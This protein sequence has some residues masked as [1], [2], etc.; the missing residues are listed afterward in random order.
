MTRITKFFVF[1]VAGLALITIIAALVLPKVIDPNNYRDKISQLVFDN[2]GLTLSIDG[3]IGWSVFPWLGLTLQ[4][5]NVKGATDKPFAE[6]GK[7][8]VSV[9]L[10]PLLSQT[11]EMQTATLVGLKLN[12]IKDKDGK[13]NWETNHKPSA[14]ATSAEASTVASTEASTTSDKSGNKQPLQIDIANVI[15]DDLVVRYQD[16]ATGKTYTID[17]ASLKTGAI[18]NQEPFDFELLARISSNEPALAFQTGLS[19]NFSFDLQNGQYTLKNYKLSA[20]PDVAQ[21]ESVNLV[22]NINY[23]QK[24][25]QIDGSMDVTEFNP[26]RLLNQIKVELPPMADPKALNKLSF[27]SQFTTDGKHFDANTLKLNLDSFHIDG[28]FKVAD[29]DTQA[30]TFQF[31]G[32]DLNLDNY[33]PPPTDETAKPSEASGSQKPAPA[34]TNEVPLIP[35]DALRPLDIKGSLKLNSLIVAKLKFENPSVQLRAANGRQEVKINS[36]F[37]KG[38]IDLDTRLDVRQ[39]GN[40]KVTTVAGLKGINLQ[41]LAEPVPALSSVEGNLN[42]DV[43]VATHGLLQSTLTKNLSGKVGFGIGNGAFTGANFDKLVC[44][45]IAQIRNKELQKKDWG[46]STQFKN[47]SGSF[48]IRNGVASNDNLTAALSNLNLK[49][50][51]KVNLIQQTMDYHIGLN[52]SGAT[53]PDSD[54]ACQVN[55]DYAGVTWP[56]RCRGKL[57]KPECGLDTER[58]ADTIAGLAKQEVQHRIEKEIEKK[59][60]GPLKDALKGFFK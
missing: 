33:L 51:G 18:R 11:V 25:M 44:E 48:D 5:V 10:L 1:V 27:N 37:Y 46:E 19:G 43:N 50:D 21:G 54:P 9:K 40:P 53:A 49:G 13:G 60:D 55:K 35:E 30:M 23:Q 24:P 14:T 31:S 12:L 58:L 39:K 52:I 28:N 45:G 16:L 29:L 6:L 3:P 4:D 26:A 41:S 32:N 59:L 42:A 38:T 20:K 17:Q 36:A 47:L 56:V 2:T 8:E 34:S 7:A 22:G 15:A 57:G